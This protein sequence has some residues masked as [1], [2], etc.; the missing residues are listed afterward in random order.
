MPLE[1]PFEKYQRGAR[2]KKGGIVALVLALVLGVAGTI[3]YGYGEHLQVQAV[4]EARANGWGV[5]T[6]CDRVGKCVRSD[7]TPPVPLGGAAD[8][9]G[10]AR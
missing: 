9:Q 8:G 4:A 7:A 10:R 2:W 6:V 5:L 1:T 3:M